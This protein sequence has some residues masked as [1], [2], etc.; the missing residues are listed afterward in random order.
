MISQ[1]VS[2]I[3]TWKVFK[4]YTRNEVIWTSL[5]EQYHRHTGELS[6]LN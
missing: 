6:V 5:H 1:C 2:G 3:L 4:T